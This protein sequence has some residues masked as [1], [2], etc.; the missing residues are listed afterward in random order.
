MIFTNTREALMRIEDVYE[1]TAG[2]YD[3][4]NTFS[5]Y[6]K[7]IFESPMI[8]LA[9]MFDLDACGWTGKLAEGLALVDKQKDFL[10]SID[11]K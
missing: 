5:T 6:D 9:M 3:A 4:Y 7:M 10:G 11:R 1:K 8:Y 2:D